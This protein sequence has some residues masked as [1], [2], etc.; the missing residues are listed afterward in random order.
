M[1]TGDEPQQKGKKNKAAIILQRQKEIQETLGN[2]KESVE[3][4]REARKHRL[5][6]DL[7]LNYTKR[8]KICALPAEDCPRDKYLF[9][10]R[11]FPKKKKRQRK[12]MRLLGAYLPISRSGTY[13]LS[14]GRENLGFLK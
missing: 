7:R 5:P 3:S 6:E 10:Q 14:L 4:K 11:Y 8:K 2:L 9:V 13:H 12:K 1:V